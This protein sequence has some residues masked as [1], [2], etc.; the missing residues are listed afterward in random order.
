MKFSATRR[1]GGFSNI[2]QEPHAP[3][4]PNGAV[5]S[6]PRVARAER[7]TLGVSERIFINPNGV[8]ATPKDTTPLGLA[9][10]SI[11]LPRVARASQP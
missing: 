9:S 3:F 6:K 7:A 11:S 1:A 10:V 5:A 8:V 4:S 2:V